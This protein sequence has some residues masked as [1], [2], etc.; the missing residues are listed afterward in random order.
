M[1]KR[2]SSRPSYR[3][4][5]AF[6]PDKQRLSPAKKTLTHRVFMMKKNLC[7]GQASWPRLQWTLPRKTASIGFWLTGETR[8]NLLK[9]HT[10][11]HHDVYRHVSLGAAGALS[12]WIT[13]VFV[14]TAA[15]HSVWT[16]NGGEFANDCCGVYVVLLTTHSIGS[17]LEVVSRF[18]LLTVRSQL[19]YVYC[20]SPKLQ[21]SLN[22]EHDKQDF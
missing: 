15:F 21:H 22:H 10:R 12:V 4:L 17:G 7:D 13:Q 19:R 8:G 3:L 16:N 20:Y 9:T 6:L 14:F 18:C 5:V 11:H 2:P 1:E